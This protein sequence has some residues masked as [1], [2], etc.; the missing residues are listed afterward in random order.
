MMVFLYCRILR[1][2]LRMG[3]S[4]PDV[5]KRQFRYCVTIV[6]VFYILLAFAKP[7]YW[8][9][10]YNMQFVDFTA[11]SEEPAEDSYRDFYYLSHLSADAAPILACLLYTARCV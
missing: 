7:D 11:V 4:Y 5:Y 8:I 10:R 3:K 9:A 1:W 6:T 2:I